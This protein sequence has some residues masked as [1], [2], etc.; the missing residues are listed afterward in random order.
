MERRFGGF[1]MCGKATELIDYVKSET[2]VGSKLIQDKVTSSVY[3]EE[4]SSI[5]L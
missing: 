4:G 3:I 5:L 2:L 1:G